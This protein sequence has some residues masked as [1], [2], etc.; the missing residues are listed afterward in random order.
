MVR[1]LSTKYTH[2]SIKSPFAVVTRSGTLGQGY[3]HELYK[4]HDNAL[5]S[6][7]IK[8]LRGKKPILHS[9]VIVPVTS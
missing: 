6:Y 9:E 5:V 8:H 1:L 7:V 4:G 2:T 3:A